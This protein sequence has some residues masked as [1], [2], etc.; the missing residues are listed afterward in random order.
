[1]FRA[2]DD[3]SQWGDA[4][5]ANV[6]FRPANEN[7]VYVFDEQ[8]S[9]GKY[10]GSWQKLDQSPKRIHTEYISM[11]RRQIGLTRTLYVDRRRKTTSNDAC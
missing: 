2:N 5:S 8:A 7:M 1:M 4:A 11:Y 9:D 10:M 6:T 3:L